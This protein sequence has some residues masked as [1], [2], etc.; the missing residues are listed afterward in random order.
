MH[1]GERLAL[2][3]AE[4]AFARPVYKSCHFRRAHYRARGFALIVVLII[5]AVLVLSSSALIISAQMNAR[6]ER[7]ADLLFIGSQFARA[8]AQYH[9]R[10]PEGAQPAY[11]ERIEDLLEDPRFPMPVRYLRQLWR[12][13][14]TGKR[15][16]GFVRVGN[17]IVGVHSLS[18]AEPVRRVALPD[19]VEVVA[20]PDSRPVHYKDWVFVARDSLS[21]QVLPTPAPSPQ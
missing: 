13:P 14:F 21:V 15:E 4:A 17:R 3:A 5:A 10:A 2:R 12:D 9:A 20:P 18:E 7:E 8:L 19:F 11:P 16:W 6:R 1:N